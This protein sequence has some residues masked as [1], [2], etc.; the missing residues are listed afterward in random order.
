MSV[1][2]H[3]RCISVK[4]YGRLPL[5]VSEVDG[6]GGGPFQA[7]K[8]WGSVSNSLPFCRLPSN[9]RVC[10][11]CVGGGGWHNYSQTHYCRYMA[12]DFKLFVRVRVLVGTLWLCR[13]LQQQRKWQEPKTKCS[14]VLVAF[15][16]HHC[17]ELIAA[18]ATEGFVPCPMKA[19]FPGN[20]F[21]FSRK[22]FIN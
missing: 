12:I 1:H 21:E 3:F 10:I 18:G 20:L 8:C 17:I 6:G 11:V 13:Q 7:T 19:K 16:S 14:F 9:V 5:D 2:V 4:R 15:P 22:Q